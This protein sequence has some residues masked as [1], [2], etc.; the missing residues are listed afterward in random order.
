M[1]D[2]PNVYQY[3]YKIFPFGSV[4]QC[5]QN[6]TSNLEITMLTKDY[7]TTTSEKVKMILEELEKELLENSQYERIELR[8]TKRTILLN[9]YDKISNIK[10]EL[11]LNNIFGILNSTLIR[12][13]LIFDSR[14]LILVNTIKDWSKRKRNKWKSQWT[15]IFIL[16]YITYNIFPS[17]N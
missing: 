1:N 7:Q 3:I 10:I 15:S 12:N 16:L 5:T 4:T 11:N 6:I 13:Y 17:K 8:E 9:C 14:A 2:C